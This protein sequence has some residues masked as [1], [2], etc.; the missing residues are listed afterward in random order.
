MHD[1]NRVRRIVGV[2]MGEA[3]PQIKETSFQSSHPKNRTIWGQDPFLGDSGTQSHVG[4]ASLPLEHVR[5][6]LLKVHGDLPWSPGQTSLRN[7]N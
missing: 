6:F 3:M 4:V 7:E 5:S 2:F 1:A